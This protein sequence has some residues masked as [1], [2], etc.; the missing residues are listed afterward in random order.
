M[1]T[2]NPMLY[3]LRVLAVEERLRN[4]LN[5]QRNIGDNLESD[6]TFENDVPININE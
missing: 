3:M 6:E 2:L 5:E 4:V 1:I